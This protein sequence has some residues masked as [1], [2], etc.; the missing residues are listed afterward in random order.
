MRIRDIIAADHQNAAER[1]QHAVNALRQILAEAKPRRPLSP[2]MARRRAER[3]KQAR[4]AL[5]DAQRACAQRLQRARQRV[6]TA[7]GP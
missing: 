2:E 5:Q 4:D 1:A 6:T 3:V 7:N